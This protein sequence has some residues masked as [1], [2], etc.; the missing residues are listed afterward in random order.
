MP[1]GPPPAMQHSVVIVASGIGRHDTPKVQNRKTPRGVLCNALWGR[2]RHFRVRIEPFQA[3]A[4][5]FWTLFPIAGREAAPKAR[6]KKES[7]RDWGAKL[8]NH[9]GAKSEDSAELF[10]FNGLTAVLFRA[11]ALDRSFASRRLGTKSDG[12]LPLRRTD[13][14]LPIIRYRRALAVGEV[15]A[16]YYGRK[17]VLT[18]AGRQAAAMLERERW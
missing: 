3:L 8:W 14:G 17:S 18:A 10:V 13:P 16:S 4:A 2:G 15:G 12:G 11:L 7:F 1:A 6:P 9:W 5:P